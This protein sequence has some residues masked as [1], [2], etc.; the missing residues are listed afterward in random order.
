MER[1]ME[2]ICDDLVAFARQVGVLKKVRRKGWIRGVGIHE[3]ESVAD[4]VFRTAI[5]AMCVSDLQG[6][7]T[8][9]LVRMALLHDMHEAVMGD[10]DAYD[11]KRV[12]I[13]ELDS[14]ELA[15]IKEMVALLP[16]PLQDPYRRL[17]IEYHRQ[18]TK[19]A[20]FLR[21]L[22]RLEMILQALEYEQEGYERVRL[23]RFWDGVEKT[24]T[25]EG[26]ELFDAL[27][28]ERCKAGTPLER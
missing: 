14:R 27:K 12:G 23:Q 10:Y 17:A 5:L 19:E 7:D 28:K 6:L 8:A 1:E 4:H 21:Q 25:E 20:R 11:K 9:K 2:E 3:P 15:A 16:A 18:E 13:E 26:Q 24:V 22:D